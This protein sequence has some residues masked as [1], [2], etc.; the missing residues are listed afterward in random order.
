MRLVN[1]ACAG[2]GVGVS[3]VVFGDPVA[4]AAADRERRLEMGRLRADHAAVLAAATR[5]GVRITD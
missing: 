2:R 1:N 3:S 4:W 5:F